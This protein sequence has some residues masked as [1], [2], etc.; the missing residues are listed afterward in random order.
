MTDTTVDQAV[1]AVIAFC[2]QARLSS[3]GSAAASEIWGIIVDYV[4][5]DH[6]RSLVD[7]AADRL[8]NVTVVARHVRES[9]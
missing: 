5:L 8:T 3:A 7:P 2:E 9:Y 4:P 6:L 1:E